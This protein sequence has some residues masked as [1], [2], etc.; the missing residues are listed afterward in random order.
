MIEV[1][2]SASRSEELIRCH[3]LLNAMT[4]VLELL[5]SCQHIKAVDRLSLSRAHL[6]YNSRPVSR[7]SHPVP[8]TSHWIRHGL[9]LVSSVPLTPSSHTL[10]EPCKLA[11]LHKITL[12]YLYS[13][14]KG[15][16]THPQQLLGAHGL[17]SCESGPYIGS[18]CQYVL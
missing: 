3:V 6:N 7:S 5:I 1:F 14:S 17:P 9:Q 13:I 12:P 16:A 4:S 15:V 8:H 11:T 10:L 18:T 2:A